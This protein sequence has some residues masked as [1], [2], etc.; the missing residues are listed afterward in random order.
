MEGGEKP[1]LE[2]KFVR[3]LETQWREVTFLSRAIRDQEGYLI[4]LFDPELI[5]GRRR[6]A[7]RKREEAGRKE[8]EP[9][10][11]QTPTSEVAGAEPRRRLT[12]AERWEQ[13]LKRV[14][15]Q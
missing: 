10:E 15:A 11:E 1:S 2:R 9:E 13:A 14:A 4:E 12:V 7:A 5:E 8:V 3:Y 6:R